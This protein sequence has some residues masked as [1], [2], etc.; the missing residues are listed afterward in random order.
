MHVLN[1]IHNA[2]GTARFSSNAISYST[3]HVKSIEELE[4][5]N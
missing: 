3:K 1:V 5:A 4:Y 2:N